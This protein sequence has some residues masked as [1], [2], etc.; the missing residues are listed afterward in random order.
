MQTKSFPAFL[1]AIAKDDAPGTFEAVVSVFSN[2]DRIGDVVMPGA[3]TDTLAVWKAS[4]DPIPVIWSHDWSDP[5]AHIGKVIDVAELEPGDERLPES[6]KDL[7][8]LWVRCQTDVGRNAKADQVQHLMK[9]RRV[10]E[11]SFGFDIIDA[12]S[13]KVDSEWRFE[14]RRLDLFEVGPCLKGMNP[15]TQLI[16]AKG[17]RIDGDRLV[18]HVVRVAVEECKKT[19]AAQLPQLIDDAITEWKAK[20]SEEPPGAKDSE[21]P[22]RSKGISPSSALLLVEAMGFDEDE[23]ESGAA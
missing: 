17:E 8:G 1:K 15:A 3:F 12:A 11:M 18:E 6:I 10:R 14:L 16:G 4:G 7:G 20:Q 19:F 5:L 22:P 21:E 9:E 13:V 23:D 2:V